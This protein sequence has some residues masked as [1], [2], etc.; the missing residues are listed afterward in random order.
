MQ[1]FAS[2]ADDPNTVNA[3][4]KFSIANQIPNPENMFYFGINPDSGE[5]FITDQGTSTHL[6]QKYM[7][8]MC[9]FFAL[10][11]FLLNAKLLFHILLLDC[12]SSVSEGQA[13]R[14]IQPRGGPWQSWC[15]EEKVWGL[16]HS[17]EQHTTR[18]QPLLH[19]R[20]A[21]WWEHTETHMMITALFEVVSIIMPDS[22]THLLAFH[23]E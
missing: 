22:E 12:R 21:C 23:Y 2:D 10:S 8:N 3:Q 15:P 18:E 5:I 4:L 7:K 16:L 1:V 14:N 19:M 20:R 6:K 13:R 11:G 17:K 9:M